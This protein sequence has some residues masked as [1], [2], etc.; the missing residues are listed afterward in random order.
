MKLSELLEV[1][2]ISNRIILYHNNEI[3][4]AD[5]LANMAENRRTDLSGEIYDS[6]KDHEVE[7]VSILNEVKHKE[8]EKRGLVKPLLPNETP[9]YVFSELMTMVFLVIDIS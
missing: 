6:Y 3:V 1:V 2:S 9:D 4:F 8:W 5:W 7:R